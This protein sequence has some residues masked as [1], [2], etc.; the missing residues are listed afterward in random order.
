MKKLGL[1]SIVCAALLMSGCAKKT[2]EVN[3]D[4]GINSI[5]DAKVVY[6]DFDKYNI[7][8]DQKPTVS[9]NAVAF[10][11]DK[12]KDQSIKVEGNCDEWGSDQYNQALGL[13][14]AKTVK[15]ALVKDGVSADRISIVSL[16]R[17]NPV[18]TEKSKN[19]DAQNRRAEF[20]PAK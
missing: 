8:D 5:S 15:N 4:S 19:C 9:T 18:C 1:F 7:R 14:R 3:T 6:F 10:N 16:G 12:L 17:A 11:S 20:K 2:P 13:K